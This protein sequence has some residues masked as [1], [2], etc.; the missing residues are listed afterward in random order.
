MI[1]VL[2]AITVEYIRNQIDS[3]TD[4]TAN[5]VEV[6]IVV[7]GTTPGA[8]DWDVADWD[9]GN[10]RY[11]YDGSLAAGTYDYWVRITMAPEVPVR[12]TGILILT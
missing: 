2:P 8:L 11:L 9:S 7:E 6:A 10:I 1:L 4:F 12:N 5:P 3:V